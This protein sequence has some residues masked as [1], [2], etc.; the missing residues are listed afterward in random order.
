[1]PHRPFDTTT[2]FA[3][4]NTYDRSL[5]VPTR[6]QSIGLTAAGIPASYPAALLDAWP[7]AVS[8]YLGDPD[9]GP[10]VLLPTPATSSAFRRVAA[11]LRRFGIPYRTARP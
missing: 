5:V 6:A 3:D 1:M 10:V 11:L 2:Y 9:N 8:G 7:E 4:G